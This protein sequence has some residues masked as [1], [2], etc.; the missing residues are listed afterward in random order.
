MKV[1]AKDFGKSRPKLEPSDLEEEAAILLLA[2]AEQLD[3]DDDEMEDGKRRSL[4]VTFEETGEKALW[5]NKTQ[6][7]AVMAYYGD[8]TDNWIG[9]PIP[10]EK[11]KVKF[12]NDTYH[13]VRICAEDD[14]ADVFKAAN[15]KAPRRVD[16]EVVA[17][18]AK[19]A[20]SAKRK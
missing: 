15:R 12:G 1:N 6:V 17:E 9:K 11:A 16:T 7:E 5:L 3:L 13:K 8:D 10:V 14:W 18:K 2:T 20:K 4:V 19:S